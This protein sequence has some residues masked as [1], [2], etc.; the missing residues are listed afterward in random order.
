MNNKFFIQKS[1]N[2][3]SNTERKSNYSRNFFFKNIYNILSNVSGYKNSINFN[4]NSKVNS[5]TSKIK[6]DLNR[7]SL[8][9]NYIQF[10]DNFLGALSRNNI[11]KVYSSKTCD[12]KNNAKITRSLNIIPN[13]KRKIDF[14]KYNFLLGQK[15]YY[16]RLFER[17]DF[18]FSSY[19]SK[20]IN[21]YLKKSQHKLNINVKN[22]KKSLF[23]TNVLF[24]KDIN[25]K[26]SFSSFKDFNTKYNKNKNLRIDNYTNKKNNKSNILKRENKLFVN[27][28]GIKSKN[29][30]SIMEQSKE[31]KNYKNL[32]VHIE[33]QKLDHNQSNET[34]NIIY[35]NYNEYLK[36]IS[37]SYSNDSER[38]TK[39]INKNVNK[40]IF[41]SLKP[42]KNKLLLN[43]KRKI[44][45]NQ[46][47]TN[48]NNISDI[49]T[50]NNKKFFKVDILF[51]NKKD[52][53]NSNKSI[54]IENLFLRKKILFDKS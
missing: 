13:K 51:S 19:Y 18:N 25:K 40:F 49:M 11:S 39:N 54:V 50:K 47:R 26:F 21:P 38:E 53:Q 23:D 42:L 8:L 35:D 34:E 37:S 46:K 45:P 14:I 12:I 4:N 20:K 6:S 31:N 7:K 36:G 10:D 2:S 32:M 28:N 9:S 24:N 3:K 52:N 44:F 48:I 41:K 5:N 16:K 43:D 1:M 15:N 27:K 22:L 33:N 29:N 30:K 17:D